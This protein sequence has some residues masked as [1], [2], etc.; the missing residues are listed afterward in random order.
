MPEEKKEGVIRAGTH[1]NFMGD[2]VPSSTSSE[3]AGDEDSKAEPAAPVEETVEGV[4][5]DGQD[6]ASQE[7]ETKAEG[8]PEAGEQ[9]GVNYLR[10]LVKQ[11]SD[12][13][14]AQ[15]MTEAPPTPKQMD[16]IAELETERDR[17]AEEVTVAV[18]GLE[19]QLVELQKKLGDG[20]LEFAEY[21]KQADSLNKQIFNK[22]RQL[23]ATSW[24]IDSRIEREKERRQEQAYNK[25]NE[26][27]RQNRDFESF[28]PQW[29][30]SKPDMADPVQGNPVSAYFQTLSQQK[31]AIIAERDARIAELE[32][33]TQNS[34]KAQAGPKQVGDQA[35]MKTF[36]PGGK[37]QGERLTAEDGMYQAML[38]TR[39]KLQQGHA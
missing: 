36:K 1:S 5:P 13:Q 32:K 18:A 31:D 11:I 38:D 20:D 10:E 25:R 33:N 30:A 2:Q 29:Q 37:P 14:K 19:E 26:F 22:Q 16:E 3:F 15:E 12:Y 17:V 8:T 9:Q 27:I 23:D 34:V 7:G 6:A 24:Q 39:E 28:Y 4:A 35:G 21:A